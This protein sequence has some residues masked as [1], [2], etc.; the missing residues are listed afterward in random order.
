MN[1]KSKTIIIDNKHG[2]RPRT[3][4]FTKNYDHWAVTI[5]I[6]NNYGYR[7][8]IVIVDNHRYRIYCANHLPKLTKKYFL[9]FMQTFLIKPLQL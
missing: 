1:L 2:Y 7:T 5:D 6:F 8:D 9:S 4:I 3:R